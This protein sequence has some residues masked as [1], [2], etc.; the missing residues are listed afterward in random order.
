M[1]PNTIKDFETIK[2]YETI[3]TIEDHDTIV[4][5]EGKKTLMS[6]AS[7]L[8]SSYIEAFYIFNNL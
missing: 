1:R 8:L 3:E 4:D 2:D 6:S 5:C 7:D